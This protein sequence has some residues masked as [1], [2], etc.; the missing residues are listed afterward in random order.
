MKRCTNCGNKGL[1]SGTTEERLEVGGIAFLAELPAMVC[2]ECGHSLVLGADMERFDMAVA[3]WLSSH[4][5]RT[6]EAFRFT[7]KA[8]GMRATDLAALVQVTPET[9]SHW[10]NGHRAIDVGVFALLGELVA[11]RIEGRDE[12]LGRLLALREPA[13]TPKRAVRVALPKAG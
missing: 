10:E 12:T 6:P 3:S 4:G 5:H 9:I 13:K 2:Q 7:R 8:L 11:D 1:L